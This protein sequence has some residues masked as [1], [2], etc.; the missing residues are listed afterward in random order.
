MS[1]KRDPVIAVLHYFENAELPL[2]QQAL[3]LA[4]QIVRRRQPKA[5]SAKPRSHKRRADGSLDAG[6][7]P[8]LN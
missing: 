3:T 4:T 8:P 2:V 6:T 7:L 1:R 5:T